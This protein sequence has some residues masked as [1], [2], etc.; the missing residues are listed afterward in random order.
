MKAVLLRCPLLVSL[1]LSSCRA[2]PRGMKR[3]YEGSEVTELRST[4]EEKPEAE[5]EAEPSPEQEE[6]ETEKVVGQNDE[7]SVLLVGKNGATCLE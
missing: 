1:N 5:K 2:L 3:L 7:E 6:M 4:F